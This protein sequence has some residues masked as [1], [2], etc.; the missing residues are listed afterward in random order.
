MMNTVVKELR[1]VSKLYL[2]DYPFGSRRSS[3]KL[4]FALHAKSSKPIRVN[5]KISKKRRMLKVA[6]SARVLP[7]VSIRISNLFQDLASLKILRSL[8]PLK[9]VITDPL[10]SVASFTRRFDRNISI[11]LEMTTMQSKTL[12]IVPLK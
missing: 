7:K 10:D 4:N 8:K 2:G 12:N 3:C 5:T 1:K 9:A 6:I 11:I